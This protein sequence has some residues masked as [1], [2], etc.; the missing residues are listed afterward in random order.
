MVS[1]FRASTPYR[2]GGSDNPHASIDPFD[3]SPAHLSSTYYGEYGVLDSMDIPHIVVCVR[4]VYALP[5]L[6]DLLRIDGSPR[7]GGTTT[8]TALLPSE[9][10]KRGLWL[11]LW[12]PAKP[13]PMKPTE[14]DMFLEGAR[15]N[16]S[17][18][19]QDNDDMGWDGRLLVQSTITICFLAVSPGKRGERGL[20]LTDGWMGWDI[21]NLYPP[22]TYLHTG[23]FTSDPPLSF[24]T[25]LGPSAN[26]HPQ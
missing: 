15:G 17:Y 5:S 18:Q 21:F 25:F 6:C 16:S 23:L 19:S 26:C 10:V 3:R 7:S 22:A 13:R 2:S 8:G 11:W 12:L 4:Y 1:W 24:G 14:C 9:T 20:Q